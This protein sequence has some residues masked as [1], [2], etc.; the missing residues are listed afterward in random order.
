[1][2]LGGV[3]LK[4]NMN[5]IGLDH[6]QHNEDYNFKNIL[7]NDEEDETTIYSTIGHTC[8]YF[9][10]DEK[11]PRKQK[12]H[13]PLRLQSDPGVPQNQL[14]KNYSSSNPMTTSCTDT[15]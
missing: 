10:I 12:T 1:M 14:L 6:V 4:T 3:G 2:G 15:G 11:H 9:E 5:N 7:L 13:K 8:N